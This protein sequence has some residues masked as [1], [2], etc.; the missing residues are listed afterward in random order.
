M[1]DDVDPAAGRDRAGAGD[2]ARCRTASERARQSSYRLRFGI[3]YIVLAA[4]MGAGSARS[5]PH[6]AR[7][8][9]R[10]PRSGRPGSRTEAWRQARSRSRTTSRRPTGSRVGSQL[11]VCARRPAAVPRSQDVNGARDRRPSR[12]LDR[13]GRG[14]RRRRDHDRH[15][16]VMYILCGLGAQCSIEEGKA[17]EAA[18]TSSCAARRSSSRSTRSSTSTASNRWSCSCRRRRTRRRRST[19]GVPEKERSA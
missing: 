12:H 7:R 6:A 5:R 16:V 14:G 19:R 2:H 3:I 10:R 11:A 18:R 17:T 9:H 1:A 15:A 8:A 13:P 4:L